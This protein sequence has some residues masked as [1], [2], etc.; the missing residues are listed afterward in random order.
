VG[1]GFMFKDSDLLGLPLRVVLG[2]RDYK[3]SGMLEIKVRKTG[4]S[5]KLPKDQVL[6][7][8]KEILKQLSE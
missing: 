8:V 6:N 3:E 4:E 2:E 5:F 7:K 1:A